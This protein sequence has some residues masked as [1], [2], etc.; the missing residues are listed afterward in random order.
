[1]TRAGAAVAAVAVLLAGAACTSGAESPAAPRESLVP[2]VVDPPPPEVHR[3]E[4]PL[5]VIGHATVPQLDLTTAQSERLTS[6]EAD[7]WRGFRVLSGGAPAR[8]VRAVERDPGTLAVVPLSAVGPT[9]VA[10][11]VAG[12]DPVRDAAGAIDLTVAGDLMLVRDVPDPTA[13]LAPL[14]ERLRRADLTVGNLESTLSRNGEP[15]QDPVT[16]S[17]GATPALVPVLR[18]AG[19]DAVSLANNHV[20]DY[21]EVALLETLRTLRSSRLQGFG[22]GRD[23]AEAGR[24]AVLNRDGVSFAFL[25]FNAI[26]ETPRATRDEPGALS[27]RMPPRT[28]PLVRSDLDHMAALVREYDEVADVVVVIP[29]WGE[30][31]VHEPWQ[32]QRDVSRR[33]VA[34]GAD[35]VVGGHPHWVQGVEA[36][37]GVPVVHSLGNFVFDMDFMEQTLEGVLLEATFWGAELKAVRFVPY[38]MDTEVFAPRVARGDAGAAILD[39][40]WSSSRGPWAP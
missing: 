21:G 22:A 13:A 17:F 9:V 12:Y 8:L 16:D 36:V 28:G 19:F 38:R 23:R 27:V 5:A 35:L 39:D 6:G 33:L 37:D 24:A 40:L 3:P 18:A 26:G 14:S 30:Q 10:A 15:T 1:M 25:G 20:G 29:H 32:V 4:E 11:R 31:Y 2:S 7:R 34:A